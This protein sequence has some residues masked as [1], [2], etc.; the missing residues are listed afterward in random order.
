MGDLELRSNPYAGVDWD[1]VGRHAAQFHTHTDHPPTDGHAGSDPPHAVVDAYRDA[2]YSVIVINEHEYNVTETTW[3][4]TEWGRDPDDLG[5][6]GLEAAELGSP[7]GVDHEILSLDADLADTTGMSVHDALDAIGDRGG[8][9][10]FAHPGRYRDADEAD[11]YLEYFESHPHAL[12]LEVVNARDRYPGDRATWD[13]VLSALAPDRLVWG[14]ANDDYH[15]EAHADAYGFDTS[16]NVLLLAELDRERV[17]DALVAG[18]F[19]YEHAAEG[20]VAP[21]FEAIRHDP[22]RGELSVD[23]RG[24]D[25][26]EWVSG[27]EVVATGPTLAYRESGVD[28]E[29]YARARAV[30]DAGS[31]SGTQPFGFA[32]ESV[33]HRLTWALDGEYLRNG[34]SQGR[35]PLL[36]RFNVAVVE[37]PVLDVVLRGGWSLQVL[38]RQVPSV[39]VDEVTAVLVIERV[40]REVLVVRPR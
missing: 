20:D 18:R 30:T 14:F 11:W 26:I 29:N 16:R 21:A 23:V 37:L 5:V 8:L 13:A 31:E 33:G 22:A 24:H 38:R 7:E 27:G 39:A 10:V 25:R 2:G 32:R 4:W 1:R 6:V 36:L 40:N 19:F 34:R 15:G 3:P 28:I 12:G 35:S 9:A 17:R